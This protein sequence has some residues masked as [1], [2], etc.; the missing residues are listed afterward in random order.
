MR[1]E[2]FLDFSQDYNL[3]PLVEEIA[4]DTFTPI[5]IYQ[6]LSTN[7]D[8]S[9]LLESAAKDRYSF[10]GLYPEIVLKRLN[11]ELRVISYDFDGEI[12]NIEYGI[13]DDLLVYMNQFIDNI[14]L[15]ELETLPPF[16]SGFVGY[17][18]YEI[19][20]KWETLYHNNPHK[21]LKESNI[22]LSILVFASLLIVMD[23]Y[24]HTIKIISNVTISDH[25]NKNE[26]IK[27]YFDHQKR[28]KRIV[29]IIENC[30]RPYNSCNDIFEELKTGND[31][32]S[33]TSKD[34][35]KNMV[36]Q[37]KEYIKT[38]DAF[39]IVLSQKFSLKS[40]IPP[41]HLYRA[42]RMINPSPYLFY[43]NFPDIKLI[44]SSPEVL[45][46]VEDKKA[47]TRPLAGTRPRGNNKEE[48]LKLKEDLLSDEKE[49]A[50]HIMLVDLGRNDLGRI[51]KIGSVQV[52]ELMGVEY[53]SR[54]MHIV[55]QVEGK[56]KNGVN[57]LEVLKSVFPAGTV[58]GAPKIRAMEIINELEK[59][60]RGVYAGTVGYIDMKGNMDTCITI[61]TIYQIQDKIYIQVGAGIVADSDPEKEYYETINKARALF[62]SLKIIRKDGSYDLTYR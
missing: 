15:L 25:M 52:T 11:N 43:L 14:N 54:V 24:N 61:R 46:K 33:N 16:S 9:Y 32:I 17:F 27:L 23:H 53:Y 10:I 39:Q 4:G 1:L 12:K 5:T 21:K 29:N 26:K 8:F 6:K 7:D 58:S 37:G 13:N 56:I 35:F 42:L 45:V 19:I 22:P 47:I 18:S 41:F 55:S 49:R 3:I 36:K 48:D 51:C 31:F 30:N 34:E 62:N 44:G 50:E 20:G 40:N 28:I 38:G 57:S 2:E 59:E 60:P